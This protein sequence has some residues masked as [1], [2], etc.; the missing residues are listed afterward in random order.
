[1]HPAQGEALQVSPGRT[2]PLGRQLQVGGRQLDPTGTR[3]LGAAS[4]L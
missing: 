3:G 1:R 4:P 2:R